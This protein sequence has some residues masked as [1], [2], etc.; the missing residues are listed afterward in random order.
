MEMGVDLKRC[1]FRVWMVKLKLS[2]WRYWTLFS[3]LSFRSTIDELRADKRKCFPVTYAKASPE[4]T[5][6]TRPSLL[7]CIWNLVLH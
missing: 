2:E 7:A 3:P 4:R 6:K 1:P 5:L